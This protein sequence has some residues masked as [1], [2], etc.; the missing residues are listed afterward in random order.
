MLERMLPRLA[1]PICDGNEDDAENG[2]VEEDDDEKK[3]VH[4]GDEDKPVSE[5]TIL[6]HQ[7][8]VRELA[9]MLGSMLR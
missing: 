9:L 2:N 4:G 3:E 6:T 7:A 5:I 1:D 8:L